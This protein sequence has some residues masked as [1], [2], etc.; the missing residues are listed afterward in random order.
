MQLPMSRRKCVRHLMMYA[1]L[2]IGLRASANTTPWYDGS[3]SVNSGHF[4]GSA[5]QSNL[6]ESTMQPPMCVPCPPMNL[7]VLYTLMSMPCSNGRSRT[8]VIT[9]LS[10]ITGRPHSWATRAISAKSGT[11]FFGLPSDSM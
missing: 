11:S 3:G 9:V 10:Q 1:M 5:V 4:F 6:P 8:G 7:V 2:P